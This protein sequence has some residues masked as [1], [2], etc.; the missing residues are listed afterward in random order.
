MPYIYGMFDGSLL[1]SI[2]I[3]CIVHIGKSLCLLDNTTLVG[4]TLKGL[5]LRLSCGL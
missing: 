1:V 2:G 4:I 5:L 3:I